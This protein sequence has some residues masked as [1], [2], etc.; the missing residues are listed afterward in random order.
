MFQE[1]AL[2]VSNVYA[3]SVCGCVPCE[4]WLWAALAFVIYETCEVGG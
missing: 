2:Y 4:A 3:S 1:L